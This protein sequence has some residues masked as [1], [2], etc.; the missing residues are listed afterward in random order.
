VIILGNPG[1]D[2]QFSARIERL[3]AYGAPIDSPNAE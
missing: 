2:Q 1:E 3:D